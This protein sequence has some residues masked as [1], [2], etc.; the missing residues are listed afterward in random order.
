M[1]QGYQ[2]N[3]DAT[4]QDSRFSRLYHIGIDSVSAIA[5]SDDQ[6][7]LPSLLEVLVLLFVIQI[8]KSEIDSL[9][10][11]LLLSIPNLTPHHVVPSA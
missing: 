6:Q 5:G 11:I 3:G 7:L 10:D 4:Q 2:L 1:V 9:Q 8:E